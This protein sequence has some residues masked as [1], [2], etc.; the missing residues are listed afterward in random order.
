MNH[1]RHCKRSHGAAADTKRQQSSRKETTMQEYKD[2]DGN[3]RERRC[4]ND[5]ND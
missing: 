4:Q 1:N 5:Q 3:G 2:W